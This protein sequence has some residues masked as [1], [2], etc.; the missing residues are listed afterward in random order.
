MG[1]YVACSDSML[2]ALISNNLVLRREDMLLKKE[3]NLW[4]VREL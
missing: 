1:I 3:L 2:V 4:K